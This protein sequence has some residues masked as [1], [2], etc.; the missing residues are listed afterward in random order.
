MGDGKNV[1]CFLF[2]ACLVPSAA[3]QNLSVEVRNS[4]VNFI[5]LLFVF[6]NIKSQKGL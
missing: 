5:L 2:F 4:K 6:T 3:P 1:F